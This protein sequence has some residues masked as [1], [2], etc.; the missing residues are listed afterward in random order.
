[1]RANRQTMDALASVQAR[2]IDQNSSIRAFA[3]KCG[4]RIFS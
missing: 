1:M 4:Y 2:F 3:S